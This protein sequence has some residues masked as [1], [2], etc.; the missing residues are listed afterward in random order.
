V[1]LVLLAL[2]IVINQLF[3]LK[4]WLKN[5]P[6]VAPPPPVDPPDDDGAGT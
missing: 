5:A 2:G 1:T 6:P 4:D 3:R